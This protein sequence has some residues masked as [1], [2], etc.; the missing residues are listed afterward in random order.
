MI[1][2]AALRSIVDHLVEEIRNLKAR[3]QSFQPETL[4]GTSPPSKNLVSPEPPG[5]HNTNQNIFEKIND[6]Q[7][8]NFRVS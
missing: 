1:E 3:S 4:S 8:K 6:K 7:Y 2:I 5:R